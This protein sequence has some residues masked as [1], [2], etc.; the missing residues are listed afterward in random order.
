[1]RAVFALNPNLARDIMD[2]EGL[3]LPLEKSS[4]QP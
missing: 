2:R 1:M 4:P 3:Y